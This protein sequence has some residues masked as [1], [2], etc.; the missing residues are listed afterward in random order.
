MIKAI[1]FDFYGVI[2]S[3]DYWQKVKRDSATAGR[4]EEVGQLGRAVNLGQIDWP[5]YLKRVA[6]DLG[7]PE[8]VVEENYIKGQIGRAH[9]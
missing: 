3:D 4:G 8:S 5:Q 7:Q 6:R 1:L 2:C 9:V